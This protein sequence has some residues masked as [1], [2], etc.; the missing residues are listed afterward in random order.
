MDYFIYLISSYTTIT[1]ILWV[2]A[3][4]YVLKQIY[5]PPKISQVNA[6]E[7]SS[8]PS[9][10]VLVPACNEA[11]T[12]RPALQSILEQDYPNL[13]VIAIN[14][15][16]ID[17]TG[18]IIDELTMKFDNLHAVHIENLPD[19][20]LGKTH[21]LKKGYEISTGDWVLATDADVCY[22]KSALR[23]IMAVALHHDR[24]HISCI[25]EMKNDGFLHETAFDGFVSLLFGQQNLEGVPDLESDDYFGFG[26]FNMFRRNI[27]D[28]TK[29]FEWLRMEVADD[30]GIARM[31]RDHGAKQGVYYAFDLLELQWYG[32]LGK[33]IKGFEKN[34]IGV[35]AHYSY[36]KGFLTPIIWLLFLMGPFVGLFSS[37]TVLQVLSAGVIVVGILFNAMASYKLER[38]L[39][40]FL[41][42]A[43]GVLFPIY[44]LTRSTFACLKRGGIKWRGTFYPVDL[45]R[46]MQR[47]RF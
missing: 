28:Q 30:M 14:D 20:W 23:S 18:K 31:L 16:S 13:E 3:Y 40:P 11:D 21:A 24:D 34:S 12:I 27:F 10:S 2:I 15:R 47:V 6:P 45:L 5:T 37:F 43:L 29:G 39:F 35:V 42:S 1:S 26:A 9:L 41:F 19:G 22:K 36:L 8:F 38:P 44:A 17:Q 46:K 7:P 32:S 33:M 25:P 4:W